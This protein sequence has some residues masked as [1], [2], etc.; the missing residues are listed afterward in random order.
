MKRLLAEIAAGDIAPVYLLWG[1][2]R[3]A[4][5]AVLAALREGL[6]AN[7]RVVEVR[8]L[9]I[10]LGAGKTRGKSS[11]DAGM[12]R[13]CPHKPSRSRSVNRRQSLLTFT[14]RWDP[15]RHLIA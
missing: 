7:P 2:D 8:Q 13:G 6:G 14:Q 11:C 12:T 10:A 3:G 15:K 9:T 1:E 5:Q 4:I